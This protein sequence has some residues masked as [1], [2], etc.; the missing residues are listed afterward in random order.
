MKQIFQDFFSSQIY[1]RIAWR[2]NF[3]ILKNYKDIIIKNMFKFADIYGDYVHHN[4]II[5]AL[6]TLSSGKERV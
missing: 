2:K 1:D 4:Y 3:I 5:R 6:K